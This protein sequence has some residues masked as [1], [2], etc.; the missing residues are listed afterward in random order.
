MLPALAAQRMATA[1]AEPQRWHAPPL[2]APP[3][4][5]SLMHWHPTRPQSYHKTSHLH[6]VEEQH[7]MVR[8]AGTLVDAPEVRALAAGVDL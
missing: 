5:R 7:L 4:T 1:T 6:V 3:R 2:H 8:D